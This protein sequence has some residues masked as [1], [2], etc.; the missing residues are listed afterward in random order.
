MFRIYTPLGLV[1]YIIITNL[2]EANISEPHDSFLVRNLPPRINPA[3]WSFNSSSQNVRREHCQ[4]YELNSRTWSGSGGHSNPGGKQFRFFIRLPY[5]LTTKREWP[6]ARD[7]ISSESTQPAFAPFYLFH[8]I[9]SLPALRATMIS[10]AIF[11]P[12][13]QSLRFEIP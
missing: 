10:S 2:S 9:F 8:S 1:I 3:L 12:C 6:P 7:A 5:V 11:K 4:I 13:L